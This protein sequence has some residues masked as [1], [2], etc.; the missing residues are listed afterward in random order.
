[1]LRRPISLVVIITF[2]FSLVGPYK[3]AHADVLGLPTPGSMVNLSPAYEPALIKGITVHKDNPFL[4]DF[5]VDTGRSGLTGD[6]F[7]DGVTAWNQCRAGASVPASHGNGELWGWDEL[8]GSLI[9]DVAALNKVEVS[10]WYWCDRLKV[11]PLDQPHDE[12]DTSLD[13]LS[14]LAAAAESPETIK[15]CFDLHPELQPPADAVAR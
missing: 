10:G 12:L 9:N 5:I 3:P 1:M 4:F 15:K 14:R 8:R 11:E 13:I 2:V 6:D 7:Q